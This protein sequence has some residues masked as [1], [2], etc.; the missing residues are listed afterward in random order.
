[1]FFNEFFSVAYTIVYKKKNRK[2]IFFRFTDFFRPLFFQHLNTFAIAVFIF[3]P[4]SPIPNSPTNF[5]WGYGD[6]FSRYLL[7]KCTL[8]NLVYLSCAQSITCFS[9]CCKKTVFKAHLLEFLLQ[10]HYIH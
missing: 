8:F 9:F 4:G 6:L 10:N 3:K 5:R 7:L 1:M 2:K